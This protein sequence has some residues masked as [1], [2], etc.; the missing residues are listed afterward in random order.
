VLVATQR[1][2]PGC[3]FLL[4][5]IVVPLLAPVACIRVESAPIAAAPGDLV[6]LAAASD[7]GAISNSTHYLAP[8]PPP[9]LS[10]KDG[11]HIIA[12]VIPKDQ[13]W[14]DDGAPIDSEML[15]TMSVEPGATPTVQVGACGRCLIPSDQPPLVVSP[16][17]R[18]PVPGF[19]AYVDLETQTSSSSLAER[20]RRSLR[21]SWPGECA[22]APYAPPQTPQPMSYAMDYPGL[23]FWPVEAFAVTPEGLLGLFSEHSNVSRRPDGSTLDPEDSSPTYSGSVLAAA[24]APGGLF[25]VASLQKTGQRGTRLDVLQ[26]TSSNGLHFIPVSGNVDMPVRPVDLVY[27]APDRVALAIGTGSPDNAKSAICTASTAPAVVTCMELNPDGVSYLGIYMNSGTRMPDGTI[28]I[29]AE[30]GFLL[31]EHA[32]D[33]TRSWTRRVDG[34][35]PSMEDHGVFIDD[36]GVSVQWRIHRLRFDNGDFDTAGYDVQ[37][38]SSVGSLLVA[39]LNGQGSEAGNVLIYGAT[40][41]RTALDPTTS[42]PGLKLIDRVVGNAGCDY[43]TVAGHPDQLRI[44]FNY[45][46][47]EVIDRTGAVIAHEPAQAFPGMSLAPDRLFSGGGY[48]FAMRN[49]GEVW[50]RDD[51]TASS[52]FV[53][54]Y[55]PVGYTDA[56]VIALIERAGDIWSIRQSG[57]VEL[58]AAG[59]VG[60]LALSGVVSGETISAATLDSKNDLF[61]LAGRGGGN[62][63]WMRTAHPGDLRLMPLALESA[64]TLSGVT[65]RDMAEAAPGV[66]VMVTDDGR[67]LVLSQ[68]KL[69]E[70]QINW[71]DP[72]TS[73][74]ESKP[75]ADPTCIDPALSAE[76]RTSDLLRRVDARLGAA[77]VTGCSTVLLRVEPFASPPRA[78]RVILD[79]ATQAQF[80]GN[81]TAAITAVRLR[82]PDN[83]FIGAN[84]W[85]RLDRESGRVSMIRPLLPDE[86]RSNA[87][88][89]SLLLVDAPGN[90]VGQTSQEFDSGAP[91]DFIA[92]PD[93]LLVAFSDGVSTKGSIR[94]VGSQ[95][96]YRF[97]DFFNHLA[98]STGREIVIGTRSGRLLIGQPVSP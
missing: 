12:F 40:I 98:H 91:H 15:A 89:D 48:T 83:V 9:R 51:T 55:G 96:S 28:V 72:S 50:R 76:H 7:S 35:T 59:Q 58:I 24:G 42:P 31:L 18:C 14:G 82:C 67:V 70:A 6:V 84:G 66:L 97:G 34:G 45:G 71:D 4:A 95:V 54:I 16:G 52:T 62:D 44:H 86:D 65:I 41:D 36:R 37:R 88:F 74:P 81:K 17:D 68:G 46:G 38:I 30:Y 23:G 93:R 64:P 3:R 57:E 5:A 11:E 87:I 2:H 26:E 61:V 47:S 69:E 92:D 19:A 56:P 79:R 13:I 80:A 60:S 8:G 94:V 22:C 20:I 32:I 1:V 75:D 27:L 21:L 39:C 90:D 10:R 85:S 29:S 49:G 78:V 25:W 53:Q 73:A 77:W 63:P 43:S 33:P